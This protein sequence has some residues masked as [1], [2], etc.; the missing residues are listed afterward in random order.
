MR[1]LVSPNRIHYRWLPDWQSAFPDAST[2][3][4]PDADA[5]AAGRDVRFDRHL[6]GTP[7]PAWSAD[8]DQLIVPGG[9]MS[10]AVFFHRASATLIVADLIENFEPGRMR[11]TAWRWLMRLSG[12][13]DPDGKMP[14]DL[15]TTFL[16]RRREVRRA[17]ERM[18]A[19]HPRRIILA[20][21][22]WY[23]ADGEAELRRAMRW[24]G[25]A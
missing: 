9:F 17:V 2:H 6:T 20:H 8:L 21:G 11:S 19:W 18:L 3:G 22:R 15:R 10:E 24:T 1:C 12:A 16:S 7:D 5:G 23:D 25:I 14:V 13:A 4:L